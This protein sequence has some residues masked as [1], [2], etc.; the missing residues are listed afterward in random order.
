MPPIPESPR[1]LSPFQGNLFF[2]HCLDFQAEDQLTPRRHVGQPCGLASWESLE[3]SL[4][5]KHR[6]LDPS[7]GK[8]DTAAKVREKSA[9]ECP[10]LETRTDSPGETP[11]V[12]QD[13]CQHW[14]G[15]L[16]FRHRLHTRS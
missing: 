12:P 2:L 16:R 11:E 6:S 14:R 5:G 7:E 3:E 4:E 9:R 13:I 15:I 8:H 10:Q 1:C